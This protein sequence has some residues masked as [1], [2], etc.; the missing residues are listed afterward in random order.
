[1]H[2]VSPDVEGASAALESGGCGC[3]D[4][5]S[6]GTDLIVDHGHTCVGVVEVTQVCHLS[7]SYCFASSGPGGEDRPRTR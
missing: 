3:G 6:R 5:A 2:E 4:D 1:V 7:R